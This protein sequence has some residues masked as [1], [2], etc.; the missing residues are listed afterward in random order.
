MEYFDL[1]SHLLVKSLPLVT[2]HSLFESSFLSYVGTVH[3]LYLR[4]AKSAQFP[5]LMGRLSSCCRQNL[6]VFKNAS[7]ISPP[8]RSLIK[9][10]AMKLLEKAIKPYE[11]ETN[12]VREMFADL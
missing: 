1:Y 11:A 8:R 2:K 10:D 9:S 4:L 6:K 12:F 3:H 7:L 5:A